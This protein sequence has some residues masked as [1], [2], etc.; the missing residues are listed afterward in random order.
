MVVVAVSSKKVVLR[1][2]G[3][4]VSWRVRTREAERGELDGSAPMLNELTSSLPNP[5]GDKL[6]E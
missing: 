6:I 2:S 5:P 1:S 4:V 3:S